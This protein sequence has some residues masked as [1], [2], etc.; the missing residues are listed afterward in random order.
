VVF[1]RNK[2]AAGERVHDSYACNIETP[3]AVVEN[4]PSI[5]ACADGISE[6]DDPPEMVLRERGGGFNLNRQQFPA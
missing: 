2:A 4:D 5:S 6:A 3:I 1:L